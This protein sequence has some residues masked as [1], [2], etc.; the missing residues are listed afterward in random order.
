MKANQDIRMMLKASN[1]LQWELADKV[2]YSHNYF[3]AKLRHELPED[4]KMKMFG[5]IREI[6]DERK[7]QS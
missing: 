7:G 5:Y 4:E 1:V 2:G 6:A 3:G